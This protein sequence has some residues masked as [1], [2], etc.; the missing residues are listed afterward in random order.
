MVSMGRDWVNK[1]MGE[2]EK[3]LDQKINPDTY[4]V[5]VR[6]VA[7]RLKA[8]TEIEDQ[9]FKDNP[10]KLKTP[11][12]LSDEMEL[13]LTK[14]SIDKVVLNEYGH[15]DNRMGQ[16]KIYASKDKNKFNP[17]EQ[18]G[19]FLEEMKN[20]SQ[21]V[22]AYKLPARKRRLFFIQIPDL[23]FGKLGRL[24]EVG[25]VYNM[26]IATER[27][28][29]AIGVFCEDAKIHKPEKIV[30]NL[31]GDIL[32][33][34][35]GKTTTKGTPQ[36]EESSIADTQ[37]KAVWLIIEGV[38]A[39]S[40]HA[41]VE[42]M[43]ISGNHDEIRSWFLGHTVEMFFWNNNNVNVNNQEIP[44]KYFRYG[45][46]LLGATHGDSDKKK[47]PFLMAQENP[48]DWGETKVREFFTGH[49][50][51][52]EKLIKSYIDEDSGVRVYTCPSLSGTD[53]WHFKEGWIGAIKEAQNHI[54][55]FELG[56]INVSICEFF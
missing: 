18:F 19:K 25:E 2:A 6:K 30:V 4:M 48:K 13:D 51:K 39:L 36:D 55:D 50:H 15:P 49:T 21:K 31:G 56:K 11:T 16:T 24:S 28:M 29:Q 23:H 54:Y 7:R 34:D 5:T 47:L 27:F 42:I 43:F 41:P 44:R 33:T 9:R 12:E 10:A 32:N 37:R 3:D 46:N 40:K 35:N 53:K 14:F 22:K 52:N 17:N 45:V 20:N 26:E 38:K 8:K 1:N